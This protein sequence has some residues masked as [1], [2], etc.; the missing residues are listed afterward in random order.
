VYED[1][2][3]EYPQTILS[4]LRDETF[5]RFLRIIWTVLYDVCG[6]ALSGYAPLPSR[7]NRDQALS[8]PYSGI[9]V[10]F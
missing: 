6:R 7:K 1:K 5:I 2:F 10:T 3:W 8:I 9:L 4:I